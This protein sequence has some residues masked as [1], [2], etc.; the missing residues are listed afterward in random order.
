M[1]PAF[2]LNA[3]GPVF[4]FLSKIVGPLAGFLVGRKT[5]GDED[6][7]A[8]QAEVLRIK[9]AE[10]KA[11]AEAPRTASEVSEALRKGTFLLALALAPLLMAC[12]SCPPVSE[13]TV[14][15]APVEYSPEFQGRLAGELDALNPGAALAAAITD[16]GKERA[17][18]RACR[19]G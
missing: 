8:A 3:V 6:Q 16:Y 9:A 19:G 17:T 18:L 2:L 5:K 11:A 7:L 13:R 15:P 4:N 10:D 12:S 14:C 1:I